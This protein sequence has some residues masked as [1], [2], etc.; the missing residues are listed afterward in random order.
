M[1]EIYAL[2]DQTISQIAAGEIIENPA[3]IIKE[4]VENAIDA[5]ADRISIRLSDNLL[6]EIRIAD[7]GDGIEKSQITKAFSRHA[8]SK[9]RTISDLDMITSLGFRGEALASIA[10]ISQ[11]ECVTK[12]AE[13]DF[14]YRFTVEKGVVSRGEPV[15]AP[16]GTTMIVRDIFYNTPVRKKFLNTTTK[17][18]RRIVE[19]VELLALSHQ[20]VSIHLSRN[21]K[22]LLH[23]KVSDDKI[24][25]IYSILGKDIAKNLLPISFDTESYKIEGFIGNNLLHRATPDREFLFVNGRGVKSN[26]I[27]RAIRKVYRSLIPLNHYPV[28]VLYITIDPILIDVN[29]HPQKQT[30]RLSNENQ[31]TT[32]L[33]R[34]AEEKLLP[35]REIPSIDALN[36]DTKKA[37][38]PVPEKTI[39]ELSRERK[40]EREKPKVPEFDY[41]DR[42]A[43][44][45]EDK[46]VY[47][48]KTEPS[49]TESS[50]DTER[51]DIETEAEATEKVQPLDVSLYQF[52]A[53]V[54]KTYVLF[55]NKKDHRVLV[56]DQHAAHERI[57]Y[58]RYSKKIRERAVATQLLLA[59]ITMHLSPEEMH[60]VVT[61]M[62]DYER[63]GIYPEVFGEQDIVI[64]EVPEHI[65]IDDFRQFFLDSI[66]LLNEGVNVKEQNIYKIMR[67]ACRSAI[68][69]G[70]TISEKEAYALLEELNDADTPFTC[71][72]GRPTMIH[73]EKRAFEKL[74]LREGL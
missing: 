44:A 71:P 46:K 47:G 67:L 23:S 16:V 15:G 3:S 31:L 6:D 29:I 60:A 73:V 55:E 74:F 39:F 27:A 5:N 38:A 42:V 9:L 59:P 32:I 68:K 66:H 51:I 21:Q 37:E 8:T 24:N 56:V 20:D 52:L 1:R 43:L 28:Y 53:V 12:T 45:A 19:V 61:H 25:H 13:S 14:A 7:N 22:T 4:L 10:N 18:I 33:E 26:D 40:I 63:L 62:A 17:E 50:P 36:E 58:E 64:R 72:H 48:D 49:L 54:F 57:L 70:D 69:A 30:I 65:L 2:S 41:S 35:K 11:M 34:L